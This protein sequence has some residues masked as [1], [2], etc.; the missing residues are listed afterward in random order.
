MSTKPENV[1]RPDPRLV[2]VDT[3]VWIQFFRVPDSPE[4]TALDVLLSLAPVAT[5]APIR[6][7]VV[8]GAPTLREFRRLREL[9]GALVDLKLP[10]D[11]WNRLEEHRFTLAR[12]GHQAA[13]VDIIIAL[14]AQAHQVA[15]WTLDR[16]FDKISSVIPLHTYRP[17]ALPH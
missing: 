10:E 6:T 3:S 4:A 16:D 17:E 14:T 12:R 13:V 8:S 11:V 15:L 2:L 1:E 9:F 7:E 5:C